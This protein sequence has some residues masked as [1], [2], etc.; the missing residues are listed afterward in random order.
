MTKIEWAQ[1]TWNPITGCT[2]ISEG[3]QNCYAK[4]MANRLRGRYGYPADDPFRVTFHPDRLDQPLKWKK[5]RMI[6]VVSMGDLFH[7]DVIVHNGIRVLGH[8]AEAP[9]HTYLFLTKRPATMKTVMAYFW[10][11]RQ[12]PRNWWLGVTAENQQRADE[13]IPILLR[14]PAAVR[15]VSYEPALG[16]VEFTHIQHENLVE[17]DALNGSHGVIRPHQGKNDCLDW[18]I[19]GGESGPGARPAHPD[20]FRS[21]RDQCKAAGVPFFFKQW[22]NFVCSYDAG[23][24]SEDKDNWKQAVARAWVRSKKSW[25]FDDGT[26]MVHVGKKSAGRLL[27]GVEHNEYPEPRVVAKEA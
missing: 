12:M 10:G 26:Q 11:K 14:I 2:P 16:Q 1:E 27:D 4:R 22:G 19:A 5:P 21:V 18:I 8:A 24:R 15:F 23:Y 25:R 13:R 20:W 3:C 7:G 6:F 9:Q 17:I